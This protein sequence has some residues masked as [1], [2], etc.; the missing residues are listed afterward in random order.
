MATAKKKKKQKKKR[1]REKKDRR[2]GR[3][4]EKTKSGSKVCVSNLETKCVSIVPS[5][6]PKIGKDW[7]I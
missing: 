4:E 6:I 5:G 3:K 2:E 1:K 7:G